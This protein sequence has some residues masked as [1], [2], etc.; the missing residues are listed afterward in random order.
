MYNGSNNMNL[1]LGSLG[2][3][4]VLGGEA[5]MWSEQV[6]ESTMHDRV[7]PRACAVAERLWSDASVADPGMAAQRLAFHRCRMVARGST[8]GPVWSE[9]CS[10]DY[11]VT[12]VGSTDLLFNPGIFALICIALMTAGM[13]V[14]AY[15]WT[16]YMQRK[17]DSVI[18][19]VYISAV[20]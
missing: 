7:W 10:A 14:G 18:S 2:P 16:W 11:P 13:V 20:R 17:Q 9:Y 15:L 12:S 6:S 4:K 3:G 8:A 1:L 19:H 5:S